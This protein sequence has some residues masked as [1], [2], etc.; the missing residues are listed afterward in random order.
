[1]FPRFLRRLRLPLPRWQ[2]SPR[3]RRR[4][5]HY[6]ER[7]FWWLVYPLTLVTTL[8]REIG[9]LLAGWWS[10]RN[11]RFLL[12]GLPSLV[13]AVAVLAFGVVVYSQ[14]RNLLATHYKFQADRSLHEVAVLEQAGKD[15]AAPLAMA[16]T[17]Y[18]RMSSLTPDDHEA[19]FGLARVLLAQKKSDDEVNSVL[20]TVAP[21]DHTG[22]GPAHYWLAMRLLQSPRPTRETIDAA[23]MHF[24]R[25][26]YYKKRPDIVAEAHSKL[27]QLYKARNLP[28]Q[29][30]KNL[31]LALRAA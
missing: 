6:R 22:Y 2:L 15:S 7:F 10:N 27:A 18:Q 30:E 20:Q 23:E 14:D 26:T 1:R 16:Q 8:F 4:L 29:A 9:R 13:L 28:E 12:Q 3:M 11:L 25:A 31:V 17:C 5:Q 24:I 21:S 19:R